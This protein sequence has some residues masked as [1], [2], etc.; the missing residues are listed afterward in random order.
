MERRPKI[1]GTCAVCKKPVQEKLVR[2]RNRPG[3]H[4]VHFLVLEYA[5]GK[6]IPKIV[7]VEHGWCVKGIKRRARRPMPPLGT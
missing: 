3:W 6:K 5:A 7:H 2:Y 4:T 1:L